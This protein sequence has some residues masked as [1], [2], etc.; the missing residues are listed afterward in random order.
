MIFGDMEG[1]RVPD[2]KSTHFYQKNVII[3]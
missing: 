2:I 1:F 3:W